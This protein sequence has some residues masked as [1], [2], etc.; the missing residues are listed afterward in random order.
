MNDGDE[1]VQKSLDGID[2][3][4]RRDAGT[5]LEI[6]GRVSWRTR[7]RQIL[8]TC[9]PATRTGSRCFSGSHSQ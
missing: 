8:S 7:R 3:K 5:L 4:R 9:R 2:P 6:M 1:S